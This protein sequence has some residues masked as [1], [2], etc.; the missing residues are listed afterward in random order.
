METVDSRH[1]FSKPIGQL[2]IMHGLRKF[3]SKNFTSGDHSNSNGKQLSDILQW[4]REKIR[5]N[6]DLVQE[7]SNSLILS[8]HNEK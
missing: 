1:I 3:A 7:T 4:A 8:G 2:N 5:N 6:D